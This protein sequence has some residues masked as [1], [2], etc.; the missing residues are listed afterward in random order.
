MGGVQRGHEVR[1]ADVL[2]RRTGDSIL[3]RRP[4]TDD[5]VVLAD[6]GVDLWLRLVSPVRV[7]E[8]CTDLARSHAAPRELVAD[9]VLAALDDLIGRGLVVG[10]G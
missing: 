2:W 10:D 3:V 8:L 7:E 5:T 4:G 6:T 1:R 9:D